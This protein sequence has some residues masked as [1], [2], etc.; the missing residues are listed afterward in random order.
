[1]EWLVK[2]VLVILKRQFKQQLF[3]SSIGGKN[4]FLLSGFRALLEKNYRNHWSVKQYAEAMHTSVSSLNRLCNETVGSPAKSIIQERLVVEAKRTLT[5]TRM[6]LEQTAYRL[7]FKDPTYFSRSFK[8][9]CGMSPGTY[10]KLNNYET[11][12]DRALR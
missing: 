3:N 9:L 5:Y 2:S 4:S 1:M 8:K 11:D 12:V 10:R 7:G 6:N